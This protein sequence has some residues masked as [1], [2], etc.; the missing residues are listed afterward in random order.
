MG[1]KFLLPLVI[2]V[3]GSGF[4]R[5]G[6][7]EGEGRGGEGMGQS[8]GKYPFFQSVLYGS[9]HPPTLTFSGFSSFFMLSLFI[10]SLDV[11]LSFL[12]SGR[13]FECCNS[14]LAASYQSFHNHSHSR[15]SVSLYFTTILTLARSLSHS[16][17][18]HDRLI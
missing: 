12:C 2:R 10:L 11:Y 6:G 18:I 9:R 4:Q 3:G 5:G 17:V 8:F 1:R 14:C 16:L 13:H 15:I 7:R